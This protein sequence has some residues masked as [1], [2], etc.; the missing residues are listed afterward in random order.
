[1][2]A[3]CCVSARWAEGLVDGWVGWQDG[4][5]G[6]PAR[7]ISAWTRQQVG[8]RDGQEDGRTEW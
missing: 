8:Q 3:A 2:I 5:T 1:M 4:R 7:R 6:Q